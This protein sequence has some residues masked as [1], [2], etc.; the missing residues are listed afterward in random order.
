MPFL[1]F[2]RDQLRSSMGI[3]SGPGSF[4]V[5]DRLR[6]GIVCGPGIICGPVQLSIQPKIPE[7]SI[8]ANGK[9][10]TWEGFRKV[11]ILLNFPNANHSTENSG[12]GTK[13]PDQKF[14]NIEHT[15]WGYSSFPKIP[16]TP[17]PFTTENY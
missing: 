12:N 3:I 17:V 1:I 8:L 7:L 15:L 10:M 6:S 13:I 14:S 4:A 16:K 5:R 9:K 2:G 11:Q